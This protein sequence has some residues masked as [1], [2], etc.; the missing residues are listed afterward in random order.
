MAMLI[1]SQ[2]WQIVTTGFIMSTLE[3]GI[4]LLLP[5]NLLEILN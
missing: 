2:E 3:E 1:K 4:F 5:K